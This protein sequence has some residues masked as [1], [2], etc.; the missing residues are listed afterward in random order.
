[1]LL[2]LPNFDIN[3][4]DLVALFGATGFRCACD[5]SEIGPGG[6]AACVEQ[7]EGGTAC[8]ETD[9]LCDCP[10]PCVPT[11]ITRKNITLNC[12]FTNS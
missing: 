3:S 7:A 6:S 9:D 12:N 2:G 11:G 5:E 10:P 4:D 1:M 8:G